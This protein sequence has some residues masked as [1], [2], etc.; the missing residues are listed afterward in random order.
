MQFE[1]I[2][3]AMIDPQE[4]GDSLG[5]VQALTQWYTARLEE[6]IRLAPDQYWWLHRR[7]KDTRQKKAPRPLA[8]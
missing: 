4:A 2:N 6:L 7:W 8:A 1:L 5:T 3:Y